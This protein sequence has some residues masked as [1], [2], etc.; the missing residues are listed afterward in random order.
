[1]KELALFHFVAVANPRP[2]RIVK[3]LSVVVPRLE[4][5][6]CIGIHRPCLK[7]RDKAVIPTT[8]PKA[9]KPA[10]SSSVRTE[11]AP[12][13]FRCKANTPA[14]HSMDIP[15]SHRQSS[16]TFFRSRWFFIHRI[17]CN[18]SGCL[19][20]ILRIDAPLGIQLGNLGNQHQPWNGQN[21][22]RDDSDQRP[23]IRA[24]P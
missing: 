13:L 22:A 19:G 18:S 1:M 7:I 17:P 8:K 6:G 21:G 9:E 10:R 3:S 11:R 12:C 5:R 16:K 15:V 14:A 23:I 2:R 24:K 20:G 4:T